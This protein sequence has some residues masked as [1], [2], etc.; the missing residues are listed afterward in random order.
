MAASLSVNARR[1]ARNLWFDQ[2]RMKSKSTASVAD[3]T[4]IRSLFSLN[5]VFPAEVTGFRSEAGQK[6]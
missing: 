4:S 2:S 6:H 3:A 1:D 5:F